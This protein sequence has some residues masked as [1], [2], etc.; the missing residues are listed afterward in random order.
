MQADSPQD[1]PPPGE[2]EPI[3]AEFEP[4]KPE[5]ASWGGKAAMRLAGLAALIALA[6][7]VGGTAGWLA[8][9]LNQPDGAAAGTGIARL[10]SQLAGLEARLNAAE[11]RPLTEM[12]PADALRT[13]DGEIRALAERVEAVEARPAGDTGAAA[14]DAALAALLDEREAALRAELDELRTRIANLPG[15]SG[16][17]ADLRPLEEAVA[18]LEARLSAQDERLEARLSAAEQHQSDA[19][20]RLARETREALEARD[21]ALLERID[22]LEARAE[23][24]AASTRTG[25]E[26][27]ERSAARILAFTALREAAQGSESFEAERAA[28][29]RLWPGAPGLAALQPHARRGV[30][31]ADELADSF[32]AAAIR[33]A[34]GETRSFFG[35]FELRPAD[36]APDSALALARQ[37]E[38]RLA[39]GDLSGAVEAIARLEGPAGA[40]AAGWLAQ[41]RA[42]LEIDAALITLRNALS[43]TA[44]GRSTP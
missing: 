21:Q 9:G 44:P 2:A 19:G 34:S 35:L 7:G 5:K 18:T 41:A 11:D 16:Q 43:D 27:V 31:S 25:A 33:S 28:L 3:D 8:A 23:Q 29:A 14:D 38:S 6:A 37:A 36:S 42:R 26:A 1:T 40:A 10:E 12:V 15:T 13:F 30:A 4:A 32:P 20:Q 22:A 24:A 39:R 17:P